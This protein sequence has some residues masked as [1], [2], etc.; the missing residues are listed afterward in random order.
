MAD[1]Q[2]AYPRFLIIPSQP[3]WNLRV[4]RNNKST[5]LV[6]REPHH[7]SGG[8]QQTYI[9]PVKKQLMNFGH[10]FITENLTERRESAIEEG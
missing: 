10:Y 6:L 9:E 4:V 3:S 5:D 8:Q 7:E 2:R 1:R